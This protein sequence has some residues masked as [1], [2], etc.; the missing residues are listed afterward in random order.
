MSE[1]PF[2]DDCGI[3]YDLSDIFAPRAADSRVF[4]W[5]VIE[6]GTLQ[7]YPKIGNS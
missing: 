7:Q 6:T 5:S 3:G 1:L 2:K 4:R